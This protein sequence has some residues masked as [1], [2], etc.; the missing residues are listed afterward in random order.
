M[1]KDKAGELKGS[2]V[3]SPLSSLK[4]RKALER[5]TP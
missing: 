3:A 5:G 4:L 1:W 2:R